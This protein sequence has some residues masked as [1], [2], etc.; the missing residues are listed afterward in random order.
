MTENSSIT[1]LKGIGEKTAVQL[2]QMG[3]SCVGDLVMH[4]PAD[5][6]DLTDVRLLKDAELGKPCMFRLKV[7]SAPYWIRRDQ[8]WNLPSLAA[9]PTFVSRNVKRIPLTGSLRTTS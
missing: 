3:I 2:G 1:V 4:F 9:L 7:T 5:Y 8:P 6:R